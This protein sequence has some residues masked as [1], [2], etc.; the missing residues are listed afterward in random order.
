MKNVL[1][2]LFLIIATALNAQVKHNWG[3]SFNLSFIPTL[4]LVRN[5]GIGGGFTI[6]S[7][8]LFYIETD[9]SS[10]KYDAINKPSNYSA[11]FLKGNQV[12]D[13]VFFS[14]LRIGKLFKIP[15][16]NI[17][18]GIETGA[19]KN[20][21]TEHY[22]TPYINNKPSNGSWVSFGSLNLGDPSHIVNSRSKIVNGLDS[23]A[24][25][26]IPFNN[27]VALS[28]AYRYN[29]NSYKPMSM[30]EFTFSIGGNLLQK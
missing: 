16:S 2:F 13:K 15:N 21:F 1:I 22:F 6:I 11:G 4:N 25:I 24:K 23:K 17:R 3:G 29:Y 26:N 19:S 5:V 9:V 14:T 12:L 18:I 7:P 28:L 30:L 20:D 8:R 27:M 10:I